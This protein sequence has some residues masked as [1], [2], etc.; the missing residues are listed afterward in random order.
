MR[1]GK[2]ALV[3]ATM[4]VGLASPLAAQTPAGF[5]V[6]AGIGANQPQSASVQPRG[7]AQTALGGNAG[8]IRFAPLPTGIIALGY[9]FGNGIRLELE[10]S[11]RVNTVDGSSGFA[12]L[13]PVTR[14]QGQLWNWGVMGNALVDLDIGT[15]WIRPYLGLGIG[16]VQSELRE[17]RVAGTAQRLAVDSSDG[18]F[19]Y[20]A[21]VGAAFPIA[22]LPGL[23][24]TAEYRFMGMTGPDYQARVINTATG[25]SQSGR[26]EVNPYHHA[27]L[28]GLR[29]TMGRQPEAPNMA[30]I[31]STPP[32]LQ[33]PP[34][35]AAAPAPLTRS[36]IIYF[37]INSA[38]LTAR[39]RELVGEAAQAARAGGTARL[40]V[41]GHTDRS[42]TPAANR[43]LSRRRAEAV[44][45]EL[46]RQGIRREDIAIT[47]FGESQ[48][49][50][51][52]RDGVREPQN[53]RVE[54]IIR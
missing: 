34:P 13:A 9:G 49:A 35:V 38:S 23:S 30:P 27:V 17:F 22:S 45:A 18:N 28:V 7:A 54:I 6:A 47:A 48:P 31:L 14:S 36:F 24:A 4:L 16:Y 52:T 40:E 42:G 12:S 8:E 53:R 29:Y 51:P 33:P 32:A 39:A 1:H 5:Y 3:S 11:L 25:A 44:A 50:V 26:V 41:N 43:A 20:Q 21:I 19:A 10:G 2:A 37:D 46:R 15:D